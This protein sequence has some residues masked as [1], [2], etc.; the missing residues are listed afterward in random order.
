MG[1]EEERKENKGNLQD[2]REKQPEG[3][4]EGVLHG[5]GGVIPGLSDLVKG[6]KQSPAFL[7]RQKAAD[8]EVERQLGKA[9]PL[10]KS[11]GSRRNIR[12]APPGVTLRASRA[13]LK[14]EE[15][16]QRAQKDV[17]TDIFD[18]GDY[19]MVIAELP[20][21]DEKDIVAEVKGD[22]LVL[23]AKAPC[24]QYHTEI[25]LPCPVKGKLRLTYNNGIL[26]ISL[27]KER[28]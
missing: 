17:V 1:Q 25:A 8:A 26:K 13:T 12:V 19:L 4:V 10:K 7:E 9:S 16:A 22:C 14:E 2:Q 20:G 21:V 15:A 11:E 5:L 6:L 23:F 18:E 3:P 28:K 24:H 27:E